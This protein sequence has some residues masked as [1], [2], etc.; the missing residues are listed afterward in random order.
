MKKKLYIILSLV[1][2]LVFLSACA[3][4]EYIVEVNDS[5]QA[6]MIEDNY[7]VY[8][9]IFV[10]AFSDS[11]GDT[12]GDLQGIIN[13]LDYLND[14][15]PNSGKSLGIDGIWLMPVMRSPSYHKYD[16][17]DYKSI[18]RD[19]GT[20]DDFEVLVDEASQRNIDIII[21]L[22]L[23]HTSIYNDWFIEAK[24]AVKTGDMQNQYVEYYTLV[25]ESEKE[26]GKTYYP[27]AG[28]YFY[29][30]NFSSQ[31]PELNMDSELVRAEIIDILQFWLGLGVKGFRLDA[32][33]YVYLNDNDKNIAFW[34]W[35]M[36]VVLA[37]NPDAYVIG[38]TWSAD[39][40][41]APYY[42]S[43]SNFDFGMAQVQGA[44]SMTANAA[45]SVNSYVNYLNYYRNLI[46]S[47]NS[48]A[49]LAPF[50]SNHD[51]NRAAGYLS[52]DD[53]RMQMAANLYILTYGSPFMYYGEEI[54]M[55]G[56]RSTENT[57]ANRR[58]A[59]LWGDRDKVR[60]PAGSTYSSDRQTNG[61][62]K[63]QLPDEN[64]LL[65]HYK[66]LIILRNANPE[67]ARGTYVALN[68][69]GNDYFGGFLSVYESNTVGVFHNTSETPITIDL[70]LYTS[71]QFSNIRGFVGKGEASLTNQT[72][73]LD[74]LTSVVIK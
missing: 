53:Y 22:V 34:N 1:A 58:L 46:T 39:T 17:I 27:L 9:E 71:Y 42:E 48:E 15:D 6:Q 14:G 56:S 38:E 29:E 7:S 21:D 68:F 54:G 36:D 57:D 70:S 50:I 69:E 40:Q 20:I 52:V 55:K 43:F 5:L 11:D 62:V 8:Y 47:Y 3:K 26:S 59:M 35:F 51:M 13:R 24:N 73:T 28:D 45:D 18:D 63:Q 33:K 2:F 60:D 32:T 10:G 23:N 30:A 4:K 19:Y 41:L 31:M 37:I 67:I 65:N 49:I 64:S 12:I 66:Q 61:T 25:T 72:L 44:I 16:V 74:G